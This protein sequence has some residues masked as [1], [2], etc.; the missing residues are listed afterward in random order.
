MKALIRDRYGLPD[1][2][3]VREVAQPDPI[4]G[5]VLLRVLAAS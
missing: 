3:E 2:L 4:E 1:V 5:E